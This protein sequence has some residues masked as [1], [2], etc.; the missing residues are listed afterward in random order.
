MSWFP[1]TFF[2]SHAYET[3]ATI[4]SPRDKKSKEFLSKRAEWKIKLF[5]EGTQDLKILIGCGCFLWVIGNITRRW[6]S[7][8]FLCLWEKAI[9]WQ[10][11]DPSRYQDHQTTFLL[12]YSMSLNL[13]FKFEK[14]FDLNF[15]KQALPSFCQSLRWKSF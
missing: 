6:T 3:N 9:S 5:N 13:P 10:N 12:H 7:N 1:F 2:T 8:N 15:L 4:Q 11:A 14:I